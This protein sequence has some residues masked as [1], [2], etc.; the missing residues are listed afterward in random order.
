MTS[1]IFDDDE[2]EFGR[3]YNGRYRMP[4]LPGE[5]GTKNG[6]GDWVPYGVQR[7][8]NLVG[9]IS[10][11]AALGRWI[12]EQ[13]LVGLVRQPSLFEE[14]TL[15][16]H[17]SDAAGVDFLRL[18]DFPEVRKALTGTWKDEDASLAGR[19]RHAA[20]AN[21]ARQAGTNRHTAWE[22]RAKTG[23]LIGTPAI[24]EQILSVEALLGEA[25]LRRV[26]GLSERV[27]RNTDVNAAGKF[28][29]I[30]IDEV[31]GDLYL[32]DLKTKR[33]DFF[34]WLE[35]D[36]QLA[37]YA[38]SGWMLSEDRQSYEPGPVHHVSLTKGVVL[39]APSDGTTPYLRRADLTRGWEI[40]QLCRRVLDERSYGKSAER[41]ALSSWPGEDLPTFSPGVV[42]I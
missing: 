22:H 40:A 39:H 2:K 9:A 17:Q 7:T 37:V 38:R 4:L 26:P 5:K 16:V 36:A 11:S 19:A 23:Q 27:V 10:E 3:M 33:R 29:D 28:D 42:D 12:L 31:T 20:G 34:S 21:E 1:S 13:T 41:K 6:Q 8:T 18:R 24:Q 35:I 30:L 15:F 25:K 14:L 32:A